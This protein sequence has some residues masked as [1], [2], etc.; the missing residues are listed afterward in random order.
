MKERRH[1]PSSAP[2]REMRR[3]GGGTEIGTGEGGRSRA[4]VVEEVATRR[5]EWRGEEVIN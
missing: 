3:E 5:G 2:S 1:R 4:T